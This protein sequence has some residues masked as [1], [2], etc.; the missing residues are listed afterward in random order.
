MLSLPHSRFRETGQDLATCGGSPGSRLWSKERGRFPRMSELQAG[1][2]VV[3]GRPR[4]RQTRRQP[5]MG[6][7][8]REARW[9]QKN[10]SRWSARFRRQRTRE[11]RSRVLHIE[12]IWS[13]EFVLFSIVPLPCFSKR[14]PY[15]DSVRCI[16][17]ALMVIRRFL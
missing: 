9:Q 12:H 16:P 15:F 5:P 10:L 11:I 3:Q 13:S 7:E 4:K 2:S 17:S 8:P 6:R 1:Q 14:V